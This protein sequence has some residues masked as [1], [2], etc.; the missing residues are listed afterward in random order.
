MTL[1]I[2]KEKNLDEC[3]A[4]KRDIGIKLFPSYDKFIMCFTMC[5]F[6]LLVP[7]MISNIC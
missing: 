2:Y 7:V 3:L 4:S 6:V 1:Q 5:L